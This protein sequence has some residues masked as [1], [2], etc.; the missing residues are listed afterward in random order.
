MPKRKKFKYEVPPLSDGRWVQAPV[1]LIYAISAREIFHFERSHLTTLLCLLVS[2]SLDAF[3]GYFKYKKIQFPLSPIII[4]LSSSL[5]L[6]AR[7]PYPYLWAAALATASKALITYKGKHFFNPTNFGVVILLQLAPSFVTGM[8]T[9]F[10]GYYLPSII[11]FILGLVTVLYAKQASVALAWIAGFLFFGSIR[12]LITHSPLLIT[13]MPTLGP[14]FLLFTF[15]M[16]TDPATTPKTKPYRILF[17]LS[18][19][20][21]DAFFRLKQ[22]PYGSFYALFI[23]SAYMPWIRDHEAKKLS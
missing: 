5:L 15:H 16:I 19:A 8:P 6:D 11:F 2:L 7:S 9:L 4:A 21:L 1:L 23:M 10:S 18:T 17:G 12:A 3:F 13:L 14:G 20:M 22:V